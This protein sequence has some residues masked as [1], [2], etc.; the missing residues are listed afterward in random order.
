MSF[1][2]Q[3][4]IYQALLDGKTIEFKSKDVKIR[5]INGMNH[6]SK[7]GGNWLLCDQEYNHQSQW[8][9]HEEPKKITLY[10]HTYEKHGEVTQTEW[11]TCHKF[12]ESKKILKTETKE[13]E[14]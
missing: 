2:T 7:R 1:K 11:S 8:S 10:R 13:V 4:E 9:L 6:V 14:I 12:P 5:L 3:A